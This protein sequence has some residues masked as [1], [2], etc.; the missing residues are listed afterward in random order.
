MHVQRALELNC[1]LKLVHPFTPRGSDLEPDG[2]LC[3]RPA[4]PTTHSAD[5]PKVNYAMDEDPITRDTAVDGDDDSETTARGDL[6]PEHDPSDHTPLGNPPEDALAQSGAG[7]SD[8]PSELWRLR[9]GDGDEI[10]SSL[11]LMDLQRGIRSGKFLPS[12]RVRPQ[13]STLWKPLTAVPELRPF[14]DPTFQ[15][16]QDRTPAGHTIAD[17]MTAQYPESWQ[18]KLRGLSSHPPPAK[19]SSQT[20]HSSPSQPTITEASAALSTADSSASSSATRMQPS[21]AELE[22][23]SPQALPPTQSQSAANEN[24]LEDL[25]SLRRQSSIPARPQVPT[26]RPISSIPPPLPS[27]RP[28]SAPPPRPSQMPLPSTAPSQP[29]VTSATPVHV[30]VQPPFSG[31]N[32]RSPQES[33]FKPGET[34]PLALHLEDADQSPHIAEKPQKKRRLTWV[35]LSILGLAGVAAVWWTR[36]DG[37][38]WWASQMARSTAPSSATPPTDALP[39]EHPSANVDVQSVVQQASTWIHTLLPDQVTKA[40]EVLDAARVQH[41]NN[42]RIHGALAQAHITLA[43]RY[44]QH[45]KQSR[46][47]QQIKYRVSSSVTPN[48]KESGRAPSDPAVAEDPSSLR[49]NMLAREHAQRAIF[50]ASEMDRASKGAGVENQANVEVQARLFTAAALRLQQKWDLLEQELEELGSLDPGV[51]VPGQAFEVQRLQEALDRHQGKAISLNG[52]P[53]NVPPENAPQEDTSAAARL[54]KAELLFDEVLGNSDPEND[55]PIYPRLA[56]VL[57]TYVSHGEAKAWLDLGRQWDAHRAQ[58]ATAEPTSNEKD[59]QEESDESTSTAP[60]EPAKPHGG[61]VQQSSSPPVTLSY[62]ELVGRA[63]SLLERGRVGRAKS[64]Y[65]R[66]LAQ[67]SQG[68]EA[69]TGMGYVSLEQGKA[70][71]AATYF[72]RASSIGHS[73]ALIGLGAAYKSLGQ[74]ERAVMAYKDYLKRNPNGPNASIARN[75]I[76]RLDT[77]RPGAE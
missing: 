76:A 38:S 18:E 69:L 42:T 51:S 3:G 55:S 33:A 71:V 68:A 53:Q 29:P 20:G 40:I 46:V 60:T 48:T 28:T 62:G 32:T 44:R 35:V 8:V 12:D 7:Q 5:E 14:F 17:G 26:V 4:V 10:H 49:A 47:A 74:T 67:R 15:G 70:S 43:E 41:P 21:K 23:A 16:D 45:S 57:G 6:V 73:G 36:G 27:R 75:Q 13:G 19:R 39:V 31:E 9:R 66:A 65:E 54:W 24:V 37:A 52:T 1:P 64:L 30:Q 50:H 34:S 63:D 2:S 56:K 25:R 59:P 22:N 77:A 58:V 61:N 72:Q 11:S